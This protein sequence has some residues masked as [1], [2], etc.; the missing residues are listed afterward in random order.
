M[1]LRDLSSKQIE[2][3]SDAF[4]SMK[5]SFFATSIVDSDITQEKLVAFFG[6]N[7]VLSCLDRVEMS[8]FAFATEPGQNVFSSFQSGENSLELEHWLELEKFLGSLQTRTQ[9]KPRQSKTSHLSVLRIK[10]FMSNSIIQKI[11][12]FINSE[13]NSVWFLKVHGFVDSTASLI[14]EQLPMGDGKMRSYEQNFLSICVRPDSSQTSYLFK[15]FNC[16]YLID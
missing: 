3:I 12:E 13:I 11:V 2:L 16:L 8:S 7:R 1:N 15:D 10:G 6:A 5:F 4:D 14:V 9:E